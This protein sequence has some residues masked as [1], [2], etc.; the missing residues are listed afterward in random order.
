VAVRWVLEQ[1]CV[2]SAIIGARHADQLGDTLAAAGWQLPEAARER[3]DT[4]SAQPH[5]YPRAMEETMM[6]RRDHA[7][8]MPA[9]PR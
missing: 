6:Q 3:L 1:P 5:R 8:K 2:A 7:V 4:I 9:R